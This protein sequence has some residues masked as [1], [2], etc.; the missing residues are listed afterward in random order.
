MPIATV[1]VV[2]H[3]LRRVILPLGIFG[4]VTACDSD[5]SISDSAAAAIPVV[6]LAA[7]STTVSQGG[8]TTLTWSSTGA[9]SCVASGG[10]S[11]IQPDSGT[12]LADP[13]NV[14]QTYTLSCD[15]AGGGSVARTTVDVAGAA[16]PTV[17]LTASPP[18][19][20]AGGTTSLS[21]TSANVTACTASGAWSGARATSGT[22]D[23]GPISTDQTFQL[24]CDGPGGRA[25][26]MTTVTVQLASLSWDAPTENV[27]GTPLDDLAGFNLYWGAA[28]RTY[29]VPVALSDPNATSHSIE[30]SAGTY[31]F[32][33]TALDLDG[34]ES[35]FSNEVSKVI[36]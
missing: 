17:L 26:A 14:S 12:F 11:G 4:A 10:W 22:E 27:D 30:L 23:S 33:M 3:V 13:I 8:R 1:S 18:G 21:W 19:V 15:G 2:S 36:F 34:N 9:D 29:G 28:S 6:S 31:Y 20:P 25:L 35:A 16:T 7:N 5:F 32:A 24:T